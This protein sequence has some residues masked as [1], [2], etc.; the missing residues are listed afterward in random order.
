MTEL[1][2]TGRDERVAVAGDDMATNDQISTESWLMDT[3]LLLVRI[4]REAKAVA[5]EIASCDDHCRAERLRAQWSRL[6]G[7]LT[8]FTIAMSDLL[9]RLSQSNSKRR[10][11]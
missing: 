8:E 2:L 3:Q 11:A 9:P 7:N 10:K 1:G 5:S 4:E 6:V